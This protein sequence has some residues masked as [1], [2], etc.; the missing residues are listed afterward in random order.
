MLAVATA[1]V[2][3]YGACNP[4]RPV[5]RLLNTGE[6][7]WYRERKYGVRFQD[8]PNTWDSKPRI[9]ERCKGDTALVYEPS[10]GFNGPMD[11]GSFYNMLQGHVNT[12]SAEWL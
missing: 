8:P 5:A 10:D 2:A 4:T 9:Y 11:R 1:G 12:G 6:R 3:A 7:V